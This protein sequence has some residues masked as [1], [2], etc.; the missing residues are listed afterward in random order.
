MTDK[1][2]FAHVVA[3]V[4]VQEHTGE[5]LY[6][7]PSNVASRDDRAA[8][9][10]AAMP[11]DDRVLLVSRSGDGE[12]L[13]RLYPELR[14]ESCADSEHP[15]IALIQED[16]VL[17]PETAALQ[18]VMEGQV[19]DTFS[20]GAPAAE[21]AAEAAGALGPPLPGSPHRRAFALESVGE[22]PGVSYTMQAKPDNAAAWTTLAVGR[23]K[24]DF[25]VDKNQFPGAAKLDLRV[26][27]STGFAQEV[28][29]T[30]SVDLA[31]DG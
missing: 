2:R 3:T 6:V 11:I 24:P 27:R 26:V 4:D 9:R 7:N 8:G 30:R 10:G 18:L 31:E 22:E 1:S 17:R 28:V 21:Q 5:I 20:A 13:D 16:I 23:D 25:T 19:L 12:E 29:E 14:F 15:K